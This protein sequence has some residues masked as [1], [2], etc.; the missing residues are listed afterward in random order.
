MDKKLILMDL[1]TTGLVIKPGAILEVGMAIVDCSTLEIVESMRQ[2]VKDPDLT[3]LSPWA[4]ETHTKS[5]LLTEIKDAAWALPLAD[6]ETLTLN[7]INRHFSPDERPILSGSSI[8]FDRKWLVEYMPRLDER[9][10][11]RMIDISGLWEWA[12]FFHNVKRPKAEVAHRSHQDI[13]G[14]LQLLKQFN[15]SFSLRLESAED[16]SQLA[17][18]KASVNGN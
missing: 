10:H 13:V 17:K 8:H 3:A 15:S 12:W 6:I 5:G 11:Y 1:E 7:L 9:L 18:F 4:K 14:S 2:V 16:F